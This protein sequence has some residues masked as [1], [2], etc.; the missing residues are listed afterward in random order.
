VLQLF[1]LCPSFFCFQLD[2]RY[3]MCAQANQLT[4]CLVWRLIVRLKSGRAFAATRWQPTPVQPAAPP[5]KTAKKLSINTVRATG[6]S[7]A[8]RAMRMAMLSAQRRTRA[9]RRFATLRHTIK[10]CTPLRQKACREAGV[11][12]PPC[13]RAGVESPPT[14]R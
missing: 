1:V 9:T 14:S 12:P 13:H 8:P 2:L 4:S 10:A 5:R 7:R 11:H 6:A 3:A